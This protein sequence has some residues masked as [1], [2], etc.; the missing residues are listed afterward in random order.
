MSLFVKFVIVKKFTLY[1]F[2][3]PFNNLILTVPV[4][5]HY[6]LHLIYTFLYYLI[7][8]VY[9]PVF[10]CA[11]VARHDNVLTNDSEF[12]FIQVSNLLQ[13]KHQ[14]RELYYSLTYCKRKCSK[15]RL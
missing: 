7:P 10:D 5:I 3:L 9:N 12:A 8:L 6:T 11:N 13:L 1:N 15:Y 2:I 4:R 14:G